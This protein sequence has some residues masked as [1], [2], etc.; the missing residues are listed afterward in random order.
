MANAIARIAQEFGTETLPDNKTHTNRMHI[1]S[2]SSN[3]VYTVA[4]RKTHGD[5]YGQWECSCMG[6]IRHRRCKHLRAML[7]A[8]NQLGSPRDQA[9]KKEAR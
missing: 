2:E 5:C 8:L 6:W 3:R 7:P 9:L 1:K 4:Q